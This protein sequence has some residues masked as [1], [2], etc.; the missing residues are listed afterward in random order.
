MQA[1]AAGC[2]LTYVTTLKLQLVNWMV[3]GLTAAKFKPLIFPMPDFSLSSAK[4]ISIYMVYDYFCLS[5][6]QFSY[7]VVHERNFESHV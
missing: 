3:V 1:C 2:A 5:P 7:K 6:A 4:Y